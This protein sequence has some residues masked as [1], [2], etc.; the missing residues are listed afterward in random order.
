L[1]NRCGHTDKIE[2]PF[3][4]VLFQRL[5]HFLDNH[6]PLAEDRRKAPLE[7]GLTDLV[8]GAFQRAEISA[9]DVVLLNYCFSLSPVGRGAQ[10]FEILPACTLFPVTAAP[11]FAGRK[12]LPHAAAG[13]VARYKYSSKSR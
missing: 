11:I 9:T 7:P 1:N 3:N 12:A 5:R 13:W 6:I 4:I 10:D 2:I 8:N